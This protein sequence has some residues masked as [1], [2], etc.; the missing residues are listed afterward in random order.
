M[1]RS[2]V[3]PLVGV[4]F[5]FALSRMGFSAWDEVHQMFTFQD[6]HLLLAFASAVPLMALG[7]WLV[8]RLSKTPPQWS[9]RSL[10]KGTIAGGILFGIG[11]A[12]S[13][14]CPAIA[15][16]Q[17]GEG[18]VL[19]LFT[20]AGIVVGNWL[21]AVAHERYFRWSTKSCLDE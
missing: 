20:L 5:G 1:S 8:R 2:W 12:V 4:G 17:L 7:W 6:L 19:A 9:T 14:A 3:T 10:H 16:V 13:G 21:Y 11:W 15:M 18:Q